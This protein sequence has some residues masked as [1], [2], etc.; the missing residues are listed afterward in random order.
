MIGNVFHHLP[1]GGEGN[2]IRFKV[3][4][5]NQEII[6]IKPDQRIE[7][8]KLNQRMVLMKSNKD[9]QSWRISRRSIMTVGKTLNY[10]IQDT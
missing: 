4:K 2:K 7:L 6:M 3:I 1:W 9:I 8:I 10:D 5:L